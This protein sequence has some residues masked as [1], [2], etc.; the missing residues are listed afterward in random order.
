MARQ[1]VV[2]FGEKTED[3]PRVE[4]LRRKGVLRWCLATGKL[5]D[6]ALLLCDYSSQTNLSSWSSS[7]SNSFRNPASHLDPSKA[8]GQAENRQYFLDQHTP[9]D[10]EHRLKLRRFCLQL[11]LN[12]YERQLMERVPDNATNPAKELK[13]LEPTDQS[14]DVPIASELLLAS[15]AHCNVS[16]ETLR[17]ALLAYKYS[18]VFE[19]NGWRFCLLFISSFFHH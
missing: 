9:L 8:R 13:P 3:Y 6:Y 16:P 12:T 11:V 15:L 10:E 14:T 17:L 5:D 1:L 19:L 2:R 18:S 7:S 4:Y